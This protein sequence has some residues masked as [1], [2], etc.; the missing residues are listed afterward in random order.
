[1]SRGNPSFDQI[2]RQLRE[3]RGLSRRELAVTIGRS[4]QFIGALEADLSKKPSVETLRSLVIALSLM[5][6]ERYRL[7]D[8]LLEVDQRLQAKTEYSSAD[9]VPFL[10][11]IV[12]SGRPV[13]QDDLSKLMAVQ[14]TLPHIMSPQTVV[15]ILSDLQS[16][17]TETEKK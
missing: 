16:D 2:L 3:S 10:Q 5:P 11:V 14:G 17:M 9:V 8:A 6:A 15:S 13:S 12:N 1:M 7:I 4:P